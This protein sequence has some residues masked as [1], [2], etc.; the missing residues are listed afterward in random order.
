MTTLILKMM[1]I[2]RRISDAMNATWPS[3]TSRR[4]EVSARM[5]DN[6]RKRRPKRSVM[7]LGFEGSDLEMGEPERRRG[8]SGES[9]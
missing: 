4:K 7:L 6:K 5:E 1:I 2:I 8:A 3:V 9:W